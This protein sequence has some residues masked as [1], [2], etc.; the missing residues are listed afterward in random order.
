MLKNVSDLPT[1]GEETGKGFLQ[2]NN[3]RDSN[4]DSKNG[5]RHYSVGRQPQDKKE[6]L[7]SI[8]GIENRIRNKY[9]TNNNNNMMMMMST[10]EAKKKQLQKFN[11]TSDKSFQLGGN[12]AGGTSNFI[13]GNNN[14]TESSLATNTNSSVN[15]ISNSNSNING[16]KKFFLERD[17]YDDNDDFISVRKRRR[18]PGVRRGQKRNRNHH[19]GTIKSSRLDGD[20]D[21][22]DVYPSS[23]RL[24]EKPSLLL[25]TPIIVMGFPKAGTS[26]IFAFFQRQGLLS[27]HWYCCGGGFSLILFLFVVACC[28]SMSASLLIFWFWQPCV[29]FYLL[30][31]HVSRLFH[32]ALCVVVF[33]FAN[34]DNVIV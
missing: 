28:V 10:T 27:Q 5:D 21:D 32:F 9:N 30:L 19:H 16:N 15:D 25:P 12:I 4:N 33:A 8:Y 14:A 18:R 26:S 1:I 13:I 11:P 17:Y 20:D 3:N 34:I 6:T 23:P 29:I 31:G 24:R 22:D 2:N 7:E